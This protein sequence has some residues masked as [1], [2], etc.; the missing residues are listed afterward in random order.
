M[1]KSGLVRRH[2]QIIA[3]LGL[4]FLFGGCRRISIDDDFR[5][6]YEQESILMPQASRSYLLSGPPGVRVDVGLDFEEGG[7]RSDRLVLTVQVGRESRMGDSLPGG[8]VSRAVCGVT[9]TND[10]VPVDV[11][12]QNTLRSAPYALRIERSPSRFCQARRLV[13]STALVQ[14]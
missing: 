2:W 7:E 14:R 1:I 13:P 4:P 8:Q 6:P 3:F 10:G 11:Q 12:N 9:L 5:S